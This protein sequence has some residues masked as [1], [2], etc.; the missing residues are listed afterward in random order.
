M[1]KM[2]I[3]M[4]LLILF[5]SMNVLS[6]DA[7]VR[8]LPIET[9]T[10]SYNDTI[11]FIGADGDFIPYAY[12]VEVWYAG[13]VDYNPNTEKETIYSHHI[14]SKGYTI[15]GDP[16]ISLLQLIVYRSGVEK[17]KITSFAQCNQSHIFPGSQTIFFDKTSSTSG[18]IDEGSGVLKVSVHI[19]ETDVMFKTNIG[20]ISVNF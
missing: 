12:N 16:T 20:N 10:V 9:K 19:Y 11:K 17:K 4:S 3:I 15:N 18:T 5:S 1:K 7:A 14:Y 8:S 2:L 13:K 6:A